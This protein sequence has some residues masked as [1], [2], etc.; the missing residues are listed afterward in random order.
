VKLNAH[1]MACKVKLL[2]YGS[3]NLLCASKLATA[4]SLLDRASNY[5]LWPAM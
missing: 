1:I 3:I 2:C 4:G 5:G